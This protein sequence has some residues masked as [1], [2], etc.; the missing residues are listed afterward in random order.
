[1]QSGVLS[2]SLLIGWTDPI[3]FCR[4][5]TLVG[6]PL[7]QSVLCAQPF[8]LGWTALRLIAALACPGLAQ[9]VVTHALA[10]PGLARLVVTHALAC[11][12]LAQLVVM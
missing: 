1:M 5:H 4:L 8:Q 2:A 9:L 6:S 3:L 12:G 11:P 7:C 10:C